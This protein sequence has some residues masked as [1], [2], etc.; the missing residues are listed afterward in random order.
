MTCHQIGYDNKTETSLAAL[1][2][3]HLDSDLQVYSG[4]QEASR[5][6]RREQKKGDPSEFQNDVHG[7][8]R[9]PSNVLTEVCPYFDGTTAAS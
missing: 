6:T 2:E 1:L 9:N 7:N 4:Y 8:I 3:M 5:R